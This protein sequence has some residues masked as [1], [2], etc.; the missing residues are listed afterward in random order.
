MGM[1]LLEALPLV[2]VGAVAP[3]VASVAWVWTVVRTLDFVEAR[4]HGTR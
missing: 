2:V 4:F 3:L 1:E